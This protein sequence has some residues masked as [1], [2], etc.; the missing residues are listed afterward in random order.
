MNSMGTKLIGKEFGVE[1][2]LCG[3]KLKMKKLDG[4][5][6]DGEKVGRGKIW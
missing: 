6:V 5:K 1:R 2:I 4:K 3:K